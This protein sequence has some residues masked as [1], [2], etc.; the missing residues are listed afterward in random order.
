MPVGQ[1][2]LRGIEYILVAQGVARYSA[3]PWWSLEQD[4]VNRCGHHPGRL[5]CP[6]AISLAELHRQ[7]RHNPCGIWPWRG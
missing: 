5:A 3:K 1:A 7:N 4:N 6:R 2:E